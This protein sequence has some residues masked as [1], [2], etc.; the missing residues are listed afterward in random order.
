M[1]RTKN[2][3]KQRL[4]ITES[5]LNKLKGIVQMA[6]KNLAERGYLELLV[7][8]LEDADVVS[9]DKVPA[10]LVEMQTSIRITD[11]DRSE[12][13]VFK[14]VFPR[15]AN[16]RDHVSVIAPLGSALLG[17]RVGEVVEINAPTRRRRIRVEEIGHFD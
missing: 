9:P 5:D 16:C 11:L 10:D 6:K 17:S 14:L 8:K 7:E 15:D 1:I 13:R 12:Q 2:K 3:V 4:A